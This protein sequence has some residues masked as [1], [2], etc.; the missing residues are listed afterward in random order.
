MT[1]R[2]RAVLDDCP[3]DSLVTVQHADE[4]YQHLAA[5]LR[6]D[7]LQRLARQVRDHSGTYTRAFGPEDNSARVL[8]LTNEDTYS[9]G[10]RMI[11][12]LETGEDP[13]DQRYLCGRGRCS[14]NKCHSAPHDELS[15]QGGND[16]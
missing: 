13:G 16:T 5:G 7:L 9:L 15:D 3:V 8:A 14:Q 10:W 6:L 12:V 1:D 2:L 4:M 11:Q